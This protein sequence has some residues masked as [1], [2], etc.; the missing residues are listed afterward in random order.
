MADTPDREGDPCPAGRPDPVRA[1]HFGVPER[2]RGFRVHVSTGFRR[3]LLR[4]GLLCAGC[5]A[6]AVVGAWMWVRIPESGSR[7]QV[8]YFA[9]AAPLTP[10][11]RMDRGELLE[12]LTRLGYDATTDSLMPGR[13]R[14]LDDGFE[15]HLHPFDYPDDPFRGGPLRVELRHGKI[16][17]IEP[18]GQIPL[19]ERLQLEPERIAGFEGDTG[20]VLAPLRLE[21]AP[22]L[23]VRTLV[24]IEDRRFYR[25]PGI[26]PV[27]IARAVRSNF[28]HDGAAVEGGSTLTQQLARSLFLHNEKTLPRK[29]VEAL[30]A[31]GLELRYTKEEILEAYLNAVYWGH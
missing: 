25:H 7:Q 27:G 29:V 15:I 24:L 13:Y 26:D 16:S 10:G 18:V 4:V 22:P 3:W 30:L 17:R 5:C 9:A 8:L 23:L 12:R 31:A 14:I 28:R 20:A 2:P 6:L 1:R 19:P 21:D 11:S